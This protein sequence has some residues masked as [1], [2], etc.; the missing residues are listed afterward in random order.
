MFGK[1]DFCPFI[2][3]GK[4]HSVKTRFS[5]HNIISELLKFDKLRQL[6]RNYIFYVCQFLI[7]AIHLHSANLIIDNYKL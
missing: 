2:L 1:S 5:L 6:I 7:I 4:Q 3:I